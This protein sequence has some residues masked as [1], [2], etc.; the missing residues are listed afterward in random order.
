MQSSSQIIPTNKPTSSFFTGRTPFP[1]PNQQCQSTEGKNNLRD[2]VQVTTVKAGRCAAGN[3][4]IYLLMLTLTVRCRAT[5]LRSGCASTVHSG[6]WIC[7]R[8]NKQ[9]RLQTVSGIQPQ[10]QQTITRLPFPGVFYLPPSLNAG[11]PLFY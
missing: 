8:L 11:F 2:T 4:A 3:H 10:Q 7:S 1:S 6:S 5:I 9:T